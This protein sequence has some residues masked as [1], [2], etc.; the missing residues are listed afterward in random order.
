[1]LYCLKITFEVKTMKSDFEAVLFDFDGT[2]ADTGEGIGKCADYAC[3]YFKKPR[4]NDEQRKA[5][6]GPPLYDSFRMLLGLTSDE[7]IKTAI[8]KYRECY[9]AGAMFDLK[10][11]DGMEE[12]LREI[13]E[14]GIKTVIASSKPEKFVK[15]IIEKLGLSEYFTLLSCPTDDNIKR[16][17]YELISSALEKL[18]V[19]TDCFSWR[20][21]QMT[22]TTLLMVFGRLLYKASSLREAWRVFVNILTV[23]NYWVLTDGSLFRMGL[24]AHQMLI[25]F[26]AMI[27]LLTVSILQEKGIRLRETIERQNLVFRWMLY[28]VAIFAIILLGIYGEEYDASAFIY[29]GF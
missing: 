2:L 7:D 16:S 24:N 22:R 28:I 18:N 29:A 11:Y 1:M 23:H 3:E 27:V 4:L 5:F 14:S 26:V 10:L 12:L 25:L 20:L 21:W 13:H 8:A 17:K 6:V 15:Q 19:N 9:V